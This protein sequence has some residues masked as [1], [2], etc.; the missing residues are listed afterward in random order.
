MDTDHE[1]CAKEDLKY[2]G[3][4]HT[5]FMPDPYLLFQAVRQ[6]IKRGSF[7]VNVRH[8]VYSIRSTEDIDMEKI[9]RYRY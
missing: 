1:T 6:Q 9:K 5:K 2:T 8:N 7:E 3:Y 4:V